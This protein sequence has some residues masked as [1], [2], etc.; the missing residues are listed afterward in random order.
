MLATVP[1]RPSSGPIRTIV[2]ID[3]RRFSIP[4]ITSVWNSMTMICLTLAI[5]LSRFFRATAISC[6]SAECH[7]AG[8][9]QA[10]TAASNLPAV[11]SSRTRS[12]S[13]A[14]VGQ[15]LLAEVP[16]E[17]DRVVDAPDGQQGQ[18]RVDD[19]AEGVDDPG[20]F[21]ERVSGAAA[22]SVPGG[23]SGRRSR[24]APRGPT[25]IVARPLPRPA[26]APRPRPTP[27]QPPP[28]AGQCGRPVVPSRAR[29]RSSAV[30]ESSSRSRVTIRHTQGLRPCRAPC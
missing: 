21:H 2:E 16:V 12:I 5:P 3:A 27:C 28:G 11:I 17:Q 25:G 13:G 20:D 30:D 4:A 14:G 26:R 9:W 23:A 1:S 18:G 29:A 15:R 7:Q 22:G 19:V 10:A 24:P 8:S 6:A